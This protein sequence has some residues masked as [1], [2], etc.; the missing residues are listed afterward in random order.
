MREDRIALENHADVPLVRRDIVDPL[1]IKEDISALNAVEPCDHPQ[2]RCL[3]AAGW[4]EQCEELTV[5]NVL[6]N[7]R[8]NCEIAIL[9][10]SVLNVNRYTHQISSKL[11]LAASNPFVLYS[12][13]YL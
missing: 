1:L 5:A 4:S 10:H 8:N 2:E 9:L 13:D 7:P 11:F 3:S 12:S 6:C